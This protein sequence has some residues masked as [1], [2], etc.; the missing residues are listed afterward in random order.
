M[1]GPGVGR[2]FRG[3]AVTRTVDT[4]IGEVPTGEGRCVLV[5]LREHGGRAYVRWRTFHRH[6]V[7]GYWYPDRRRAFV[8]PL[9]HAAALA[10]AILAASKGEAVSPVPPWLAAIDARREHVARAFDELGAPER[11]RTRAWR[12]CDRGWGMDP[13][14]GERI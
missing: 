11:L 9:E 10:E 12:R 13:K 3:H 6:R 7:G 5:Y 8:V 1:T 2:G 4:F 14:K